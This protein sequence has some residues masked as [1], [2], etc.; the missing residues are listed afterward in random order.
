MKRKAKR[1]CVLTLSDR[2]LYSL[3]RG[4]ALL[5]AQANQPQSQRNIT[6]AEMRALARRLA[7]T[8]ATIA[9]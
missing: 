2:E 1:A 8:Y 6:L 5:I 4:Q 9:D 3:L 7:R